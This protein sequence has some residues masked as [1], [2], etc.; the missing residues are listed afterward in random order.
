MRPLLPVL[1]FLL[2]GCSSASAPDDARGD[3]GRLSFRFDGPGCSPFDGCSPRQSIARGAH[4]VL[5]ARGD[6]AGA[7]YH[8]TIR[9]PGLVIEQEGLACMCTE[10]LEGGGSQG[11]SPGPG[12]QCGA[13]ASTTCART[14]LLRAEQVGTVTLEVTGPNGDLVD[15][16][17]L[18]I[19][20][21]ARL[22]PVVSAA[23]PAGG[24]L[25][26]LLPVADGTF[27]TDLPMDLY[28]DT[29]AVDARGVELR[30]GKDDVTFAGEAVVFGS[31]SKPRQPADIRVDA[32]GLGLTSTFLVRAR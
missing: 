31:M 17:A 24:T 28:F 13:R 4:V 18:G 30:K 19:V 27:A 21:P 6:D 1:L 14:F 10:Q 5:S 7:D 15:K 8:G 3:L 2:A 20:Q 29:K 16:I 9:A 25:D 12:Q 32:T 26:P 11:W 23:R 22:E